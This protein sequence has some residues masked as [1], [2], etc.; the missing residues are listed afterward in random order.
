[1]SGRQR[2][3]YRVERRDFPA[4]FP[5]RLECLRTESQ[6]SWRGLARALRLPARSLRR[7]RAGTRPDSAHLFVLLEF[8]AERGLL[9]CLLPEAL[10]RIDSATDEP[11]NHDQN[12]GAGVRRSTE[13]QAEP[14]GPER[15]SEVRSETNKG[16]DTCAS[17]N[18]SP[19]TRRK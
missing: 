5:E 18:A 3:V 7:W 19:A 17:A 9:H 14:S 4:D 2:W 10:Q 13:R 1:M 12:G 6:L 16:T 8:A 11:V 15:S